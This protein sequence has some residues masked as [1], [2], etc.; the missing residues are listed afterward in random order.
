MLVPR[1]TWTDRNSG[2]AQEDEFRV[3]RDT[4]PFDAES[5]PA[6]LTT[7]AADS[8]EFIDDSIEISGTYYY[9]IGAVKGAMEAITFSAAVVLPNAAPDYAVTIPSGKVSSDLANFPLLIDLADMP[10]SFWT[11][12]SRGGENLR[13]YAADGVTELPLDV[14]TCLN[15]TQQGCLAVKATVT[16]ASATTII[17]RPLIGAPRVLA[18][19][20]YG[21]NA[22]WSDYQAVLAGGQDFQ[23]RTGKSL[24]RTWGYPQGYELVSTSGSVTGAQ[25]VVGDGST[26][27][28]IGTNA[29]RK[30]DATLATV[31]DSNLNPA[32][33]AGGSTC[34]GGCYHDGKIY[35]LTASPQKIAVFDYGT[36]DFIT[37]FDIS[38]TGTGAGGL[39]YN[40]EDGLLYAVLFDTTSPY[41]L[42][43][44]K[45]DPVDGSYEGTLTVQTQSGSGVPDAQ[46]VIWYRGAF[47]IPSS[48]TSR[49]W[50][51]S[52]VGLVTEGG[53]LG[54][55]GGTIQDGFATGDSIYLFVLTGSETGQVQ[56][57]RPFVD[58]F[59]GGMRLTANGR[60]TMPVT[61]TTVW[62]VRA[63]ARRSDA[64]VRVFAAMSPGGSTFGNSV[65]M[66]W[67]GSNIRPAYDSS[68]LNLDFSSP[69]APGTSTD[70]MVHLAYDGTTARH[71]WYNGG[72]KITDSVIVAR[73]SD[74]DFVIFGG[75]RETSDTNS[76][77]GRIGL[78]YMRNGVLSD[79][80]IAAEYANYTDAAFYSIVEV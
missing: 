44:L 62:T 25:G 41:P 8:E 14:I 28:V 80:W 2:A 48:G 20:T 57:W 67:G 7:L 12:A 24:A 17:I 45:Y 32:G 35:V 42:T 60:V 75:E 64:T 77:R 23:N 70:F 18:A 36:L 1:F 46:G 74:L 66:A 54:Q 6:V 33:D 39:A 4:A 3:Y 34:G 9:G 53:E 31:T 58:S 56:R 76:W 37:A 30:Y 73:G 22:V 78:C 65:N 69:P 68:N 47:Y 13:A 72:S 49:L 38:A 16:S 59:G 79:A 19:A 63:T 43:M 10:T 11:H 61:P 52:T 21:R 50:R 27:V 29:L 71:A 51:I 26:F 55:T 40:P 15:D 5:L